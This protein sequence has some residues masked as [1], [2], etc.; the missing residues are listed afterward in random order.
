MV[1]TVV[2]TAP[3]TTTITED[4]AAAIIQLTAATAAQTAAILA[5]IGPTSAVTPGTLSNQV[6]GVAQQLGFISNNIAIM[7]QQNIQTM[8]AITDIASA[9]RQLAQAINQ[10]ES[11]HSIAIADQLHNNQFQQA[12]TKA[13]LLRN[14]IE[15]QAAPSFKDTLENTVKNSQ[16]IHTS[17]AVASQVTQVSNNIFTKLENYIKNSWLVTKTEALFKQIATSI[18]LSKLFDKVADPAASVSATT[19]EL[20]SIQICLSPE[21]LSKTP[22]SVD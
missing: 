3:G 10:M 6:W 18:G 20:A 7:Q 9:A 16:E 2:A 4:T 14:G 12:E 21:V 17:A 1:T 8:Q 22:P 5:S 11:T 13:A 19:A 15:P